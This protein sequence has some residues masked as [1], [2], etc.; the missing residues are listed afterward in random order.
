MCIQCAAGDAPVKMKRQWIHH[1]AKTGK[2]VVCTAH[3][4]KPST[5]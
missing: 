4:L 3:D 5:S 2:L 1:D